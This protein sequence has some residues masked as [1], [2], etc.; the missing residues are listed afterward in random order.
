MIKSFLTLIFYFRTFMCLVSDSEALTVLAS[1]GICLNL[2]ATFI[3]SVFVFIW[4]IIGCVWVFRIRS[5]VQFKDPKNQTTYCQPVLYK[6][7][8]VLLILTIVWAVLQCCVS[9]FRGCCKSEKK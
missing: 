7:T 3:I 4:F 5:E 6:A 2:L 8:F 1:C 9:C